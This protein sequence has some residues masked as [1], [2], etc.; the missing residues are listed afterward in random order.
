MKDPEALRKVDVLIHSGD[1]TMCGG[2]KVYKRAMD[3]INAIPA[4]I[5]LVI[6]GNHDLELDPKY[7][8]THLDEGDEIEEFEQALAFLKN[9]AGITYLEKGY[10][11]IKLPD[12]RFSTLYAGL[13]SQSSAI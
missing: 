3:T 1:L 6:P 12:G 4:T 2:M 5:R 10:H 11:D 7:W 9:N 8:A 13:T